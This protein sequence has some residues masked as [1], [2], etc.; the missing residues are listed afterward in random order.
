MA[1]SE[2]KYTTVLSFNQSLELAKA[3][4]NRDSSGDPTRENVGTGD[5][6]T[7]VFYFDKGFMIRNSETLYTGGLTET[8]S[9]AT[10]TY[11]TDYTIDY[12]LGKLTLTATGVSTVSTSNIYA[13]YSYNKFNQEDTLLYQRLLRAEAEIDEA[14]NNVFF[15][16]DATT[17]GFTE[18]TDENQEGQGSTNQVYALENYPINS[19]TTTNTGAI[20]AGSTSI[21]V[22][23]T[24]GFPS[25]GY[26]AIESDK[27]TYTGKSSTT[28]TG[29][30]GVLG[31]SASK[32]VTSWVIERSTDGEGNSPTYQTLEYLEDYDIDFT[33]G[34]VMLTKD[35]VFADVITNYTTPPEAVWNRFRASYQHGYGSIPSD[36]TRC[37]HLIAGKEGYNA[38]VLNALGRG[39]DGFSSDGITNVDSWIKNTL[40]KYKA[41]KIKALKP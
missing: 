22:S 38:Q 6:S 18:I 12:D 2:P 1:P 3:I 15:D 25:S 37:T 29:C 31:H 40:A 35:E 20:S 33:S 41:W 10:L 5:A 30:T 16:S 19:I 39:T 34:E 7:T 36:I 11:T 26:V 17:P 21:V 23:S 27:I 8:G 14:V 28:F 24:N 13:A 32:T 4:P 9:T